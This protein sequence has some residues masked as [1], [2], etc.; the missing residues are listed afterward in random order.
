MIQTEQQLFLR[1]ENGIAKRRFRELPGDQKKRRFCPA[2]RFGP[3]LGKIE[4]FTLARLLRIQKR[5]QKLV[6]RLLPDILQSF[7][8]GKDE[9]PI[10]S[11]IAKEKAEAFP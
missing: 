8:Q 6:K 11:G 1:A 2:V 9:I 3:F 7:D 5:L 4:K 10:G